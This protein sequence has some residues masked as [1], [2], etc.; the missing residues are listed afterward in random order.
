M[1]LDS[2]TIA[3]VKE[4]AE[5]YFSKG[6]FKAAIEAYEK[7]EEY[8]RSDPRIFIRMGDSA[9]KIHMDVKAAEYYS[10]AIEPFIKSGFAI[11]AIGVCKMIMQI[12]PS[13]EDVQKKLAELVGD[14]GGG[15]RSPVASAP[16]VS[17]QPAPP[18][19]PPVAPPSSPGSMP[20]LSS[21]GG[22]DNVEDVE[23]VEE[24]EEAAP[25]TAP[26]PEQAGGQ[27]ATP[28]KKLTFPR[29]PLFSDF[30]KEELF[31][32][33]RKVHYR[34][35]DEG[36]TIFSEDD[37]GDSIFIVVD[38]EAEVTGKKNDGENIV[39][40]NL[41]EGA[42]FGEFGFF[43]GA[44]RQTNVIASTQLGALE[45]KKSDMDEI[46]AKYPR[47]SRVLFD[48]YKERV[49]D[50]LMALSD[51]FAPMSYED[52]MEILKHV[53]SEFFKKG[54]DLMV[55]GEAGDTMF[56]IKSGLVEVWV[57]GTSGE[58]KSVTDLKE[59]DFVGEI[60]LATNKPRVATVTAL[61]DTEVVIYSRPMLRH[62]L[63]KYPE[64]KE[65]LTGVIKSRV[66][67]STA[68][69]KADDNPLI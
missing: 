48:F 9:R 1:A 20:P 5:K 2:G 61:E 43:S 49:V 33:V 6:K 26:A 31:D 51:I 10:K 45:L 57:N 60:A 25:A 58:R 63:E 14:Q 38:G 7:I 34:E 69:K 68:R 19:A 22:G 40:A 54:T 28:Q 4:K 55:E 44:K 12:D 64:V 50:R 65:I 18:S 15:G 53:K 30:K 62:I 37:D 52:R 42:F 47:V 13:R 35:F 39:I 59:G 8:G 29:T 56:L 46:I 16:P 27:T 21:V 11:K 66:S 41:K 3:K 17:T 67:R 24:I 36:A 23:E 32:V